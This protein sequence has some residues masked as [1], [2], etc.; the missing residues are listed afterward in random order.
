MG[1][2]TSSP[3]QLGQR[4]RSVRAQ[5][6]QN[7]HSKEQIRASGE[8]GGKSRS[9][10]SQPGR[11][12]SI[13]V[14]FRKNAGAHRL[15]AVTFALFGNPFS[16]GNSIAFGG[17]PLPAGGSPRGKKKGV[18]RE[19]KE[20][21]GVSDPAVRLRPDGDLGPGAARATPADLAVGFNRP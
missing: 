1:R 6:T 21:S 9:Q 5:S 20:S 16:S 11:I 18:C 13:L 19:S 2:W 14:S 15:R 4:P 17:F 10:H 12:S 7:V 8:S 3:E